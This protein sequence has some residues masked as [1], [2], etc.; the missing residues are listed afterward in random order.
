MEYT[1]T[2]ITKTPITET[3]KSILTDAIDEKSA[4][5]SVSQE[6]NELIELVMRQTTYDRETATT[7][8]IKFNYDVMQVLR[9]FMR[10]PEKKV[11]KPS[12]IN[13]AIYKELRTELNSVVINL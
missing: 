12:S 7:K 4:T 9:E 5:P 6:Q 2:P 1:E 10:I 11:E 8:L 3:L 13:Q